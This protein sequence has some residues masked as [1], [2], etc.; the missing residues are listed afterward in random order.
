MAINIQQPHWGKAWWCKILKEMLWRGWHSEDEVLF[1]GTPSKIQGHNMSSCN[2]VKFPLTCNE[3]PTCSPLNAGGK[4]SSPLK[5]LTLSFFPACKKRQELFAPASSGFAWTETCCTWE[6]GEYS[7][8]FISLPPLSLSNILPQPVI[9]CRDQL[10]YSN[11]D[12][13]H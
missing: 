8:V 7:H 6:K 9:F 13:F 10:H 2:T 5:F 1:Y 3:I 12:I 4:L 11:I